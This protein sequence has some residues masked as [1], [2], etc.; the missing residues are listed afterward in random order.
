MLAASPQPWN[1][2]TLCK[3]TH[4]ALRTARNLYQRPA[5]TPSLKIL[6]A[7]GLAKKTKKNT[8]RDQTKAAASA[9]TVPDGSNL[10]DLFAAVVEDGDPLTG[11]GQ[12]F[13]RRP[14][15][16]TPDR[17]VRGFPARPGRGG[18]NS[19][20]RVRSWLRG[21]NGR[22]AHLH[23]PEMK[24]DVSQMFKEDPCKPVGWLHRAAKPSE[25]IC[26]LG[27]MRR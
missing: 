10:V 9:T 20:V 17:F 12:H 16:K 13:P 6:R 22:R 4:L 19:G 7:P 8:S 24:V 3:S 2:K 21:W 27:G 5:P 26:C 14:E 15:Q 25:R 1:Q 11:A 23:S 18:V